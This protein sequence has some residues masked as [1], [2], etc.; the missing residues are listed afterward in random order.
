MVAANGASPRSLISR[1][2]REDLGAAAT[3][4]NFPSLLGAL[5]LLSSLLASVDA[6][7]GT[8]VGPFRD[9][10]KLNTNDISPQEDPKRPNTVWLTSDTLGP[11]GQVMR[12]YW[13]QLTAWLEDQRSGV[14]GLTLDEEGR[15][16]QFV[17]IGIIPT[18]LLNGCPLILG[19]FPKH[20][21]TLTAYEWL[22]GTGFFMQTRTLEEWILKR[23]NG[24]DFSVVMLVN[25][26]A[27]GHPPLQPR[28]SSRS[29]KE[30][31]APSPPSP[32]NTN[33]H[34]AKL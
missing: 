2:R 17:K 15:R 32:R 34:R 31:S 3:R 21:D 22:V 33:P 8:R 16:A 12:N 7:E 30:K 4:M 26:P 28:P 23:N 9:F 5:C 14:F 24:D 11:Q 6:S 20:K 18:S 25:D 19:V 1:G 27:I 10:F 29:S 13:G